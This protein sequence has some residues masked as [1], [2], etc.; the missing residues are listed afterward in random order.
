[1]KHFTP[2]FYGLV[3]II[4]AWVIYFILAAF[5]PPIGLISVLLTF[6]GFILWVVLNMSLFEYWDN[7]REKIYNHIKQCYIKY[8]RRE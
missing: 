2:L 6:S 1:M 3:T 7:N 4:D 5:S 8:S